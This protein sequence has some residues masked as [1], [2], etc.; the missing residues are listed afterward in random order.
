MR[1]PGRLRRTLAI[2]LAGTAS[3]AV[4]TATTTPVAAE[5]ATE[6][7]SAADDFYDPP[8]P[9]PP[10]RNGDLIKH[11]PSEF[12]LD[13][14]KLLPA[15]AEVRRIMYRSTDTHDR[16]IPVTGVVL[17]PHVPWIG[18]GPR[19][20]IGYAPGTQG[21]GDNCAPSKAL[22]AGL[23]YEGPFIDGLLKRGYGVVVTDYEGLGTPG[24]HTYVNRAAEGHALLDAVRA[25]Q[26]LAE[27]NLPDAGPVAVVGYSQG[28]GASASAAELH[29][30][31]APELELKGAY[32]G[33]PPADL[34]V[35]ARNLDGHYAA[36]FI[37]YALHSLDYAYPELNIMD[38]LN[39]KGRRMA[40]EIIPKCT[41]QAIIDYAFTKSTTLTKDG[42]PL[43]AYLDEEPY[44]SRVAEQRIGERRPTVP[45]LVVHSKLDDIVPYDQGRRMALDWCAKGV[46]VQLSSSLVP[47]HVGGAIRAFP[48]MFAWLEGRFAGLPA[49]SNCGKF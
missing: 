23:E 39:E 33:A 20:I 8:S 29:P 13:P 28:G 46:T 19:P 40:E 42:R 1:P 5:P 22:A 48:E 38:L 44:A 18:A 45:T 37:G 35:M 3:L 9:L 24:M 21:I 16:P 15:P 4:L 27:A 6:V 7:A 47:T 43:E 36:G 14:L 32:A 49:P 41:P 34:A 26:R 10:G 11:E 25:A 30:E 31:Y 17:T 12:Y 2:L